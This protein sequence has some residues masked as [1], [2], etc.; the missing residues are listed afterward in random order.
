MS[1]LRIGI[2]QIVF[3]LFLCL[4][5]SLGLMKPSVGALYAAVT[6]TDFVFPVLFIFWLLDIV[7]SDGRFRWRPEFSAFAF[8]FLVLLISAVF[9]IDPTRSYIKLTSAIYLILL[10]VIAANVARTSAR[11]KATMLAWIAGSLISLVAGLLAIGLFYTEPESDLLA[12]LTHHYGSL[13][14]VP[15][16]RVSSTFV[17]ASM[18]CNYL[19]VTLVIALLAAKLRWIGRPWITIVIAAIAISA[20]FTFSIALGGFALAI[21]LWFWTTSEKPKTS[22]LSL[23]VGIFVAV[24]FLAIAPF[25][26]SPG[27]GGSFFEPSARAR[28]WSE[29]ER[30]FI[31]DPV[32]GNGFGIAVANIVFQNSDG[33]VSLLTDAHNVFLS[34]AAQAGI[35]GLVAIIAIVFVILRTGLIDRPGS[36]EIKL[37]RKGLA[38]AFFTAFVYDGMTG[39]FEDARHLWVLIGLILAADSIDET[40]ES[41]SLN[42]A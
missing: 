25:S 34:I 40:E 19:T 30:V 1:K 10:A 41:T 26:L 33:S 28:I 29:A 36:T 17:S 38:I 31:A 4:V 35:G 15:F 16:P 6:P 9:S 39:A 2:G 18:F 21:G 24:A 13:P 27:S 32:T 37:I 11:L 22:K 3:G 14:S 42:S 23:A 5:F 8:F 20:L 12:L 7:L